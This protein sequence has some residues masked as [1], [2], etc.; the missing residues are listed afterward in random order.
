MEC[1]TR[2][3]LAG[4]GCVAVLVLL[5]PGSGGSQTGPEPKPPQRPAAPPE[6]GKLRI[7]C[8][9]AHPDDCELQAGGVALLWAGQGHHVKFVSVTNG[10]IGHWREA[11]GPLARRRKAEVEAADRLLGVTTEV[12]DIHDGELLPTLENRRKI[13]RLIRE[14][15]ADVVMS[16]R[17][18]DY[19]PDHRYTG[20]LV[21]DSAYMV[22]VPFFCPDVPPLKSNPVFLFYPDSFQKPNPFQA[23]VAVSIDS[24]MD[25][26]LDALDTLESQFYEGGALGSAD[27][28]PT[29]PQK[30]A[31]RRRE[32]RTRHAGRNQAIAQR[33][34][35]KLAEWYG[36]DKAQ[37]VQH[38][39]AFE[40]CE[41]GRRPDKKALAQLFPFFGE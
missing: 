6:D 37:N 22:A 39:E 13:T 40:I 28:I 12:L 16:H 25:R 20:V 41:Y 14:W 10:D 27:L 24:V 5:W 17:P 19:H 34:R 38:A 33:L 8:F 26:K 9:G 32:V 1:R 18:N 36:K 3:L 21:Q 2:R 11:G 23:D 30:Q 4:L 15:K 7:L 31:Q 29:D 35:E